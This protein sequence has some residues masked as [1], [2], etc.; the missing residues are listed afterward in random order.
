MGWMTRS[1]D[2]YGPLIDDYVETRTLSCLS[3]FSLFVATPN[4]FRPQ[5]FPPPSMHIRTEWVEFCSVNVQL[6]LSP[7]LAK[8]WWITPSFGHILNANWTNFK[9]CWFR[10]PRSNN[11]LEVLFVTLGWQIFYNWR[12]GDSLQ[13]KWQICKTGLDQWEQTRDNPRKLKNNGIYT[14]KKNQRKLYRD[15]CINQRNVP[16]CPWKH[17]EWIAVNRWTFPFNAHTKG[18]WW[19]PKVQ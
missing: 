12:S 8:S 7:V 1:L 17:V 13:L 15:F 5:I 4:H 10:I 9:F 3:P 2:F 6:L 14:D 16:G 19:A 11:S 18:K